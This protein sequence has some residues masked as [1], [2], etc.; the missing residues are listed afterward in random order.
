MKHATLAFLLSLGLTASAAS[1]ELSWTM[2]DGH[3]EKE[4]RDLVETDGISSFK[5]PASVLRAKGAKRLALTP[6]FATAQKGEEGYWVVPT[7]QYGTFRC[8]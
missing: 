7:G 6:D 4:T 5:L 3:V 8:D 2:K 1:L